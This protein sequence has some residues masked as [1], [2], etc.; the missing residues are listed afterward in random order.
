MERKDIM[1]DVLQAAGE[2]NGRK[3]WKRFT[4][5]DCFGVRIAGQEE[6][7]LG[8]VLGNAGEEYG[9]SLFRGPQAV[10]S[11]A[12]L[13]TPEGPGDDAPEDI[14]ILS[15]TMVAFGDL[16]PE[17][18]AA[19]REA[20]Q[21]P[22][23]NEQVPHF[24]AKAPRRQPGSPDESDFRLLLLA[25]R[26]VVEADKQKLLRPARL[27]DKGGVYV[28]YI[29]GE[30][31]APQVTVTRERLPRGGGS[32]TMPFVGERLDLEGLPRL[33]ATWLVGMPTV[34]VGIEGDERITQMVLVVDEASEYIFEGKPVMGGDLGEAVRIVGQTLHGSGRRGP[35]GLP[36]KIVFSSRK[37]H[38]AMAPRL[39]AAGVE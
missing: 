26:G 20:G 31:A 5:E 23:Y 3:L 14:N 2:F 7:M 4:N 6:M 17:T 38:D 35:K 30:A 36:R 22:R 25:L 24:L 1:R 21:H 16:L 29:S 34:P 18:Q 19:F 33:D 37:L 12:A 11:L 10:A 32:R 8:V 9:L 28:L 15:F 39:T 13:L 27:D